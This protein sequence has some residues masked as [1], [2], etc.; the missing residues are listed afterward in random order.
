MYTH[1]EL[2]CQFV[3]DDSL[4]ISLNNL[5][6]TVSS[7]STKK[8]K[9]KSSYFRLCTL[10]IHSSLKAFHSTAVADLCSSH[11]LDLIALT[12]TWIKPNSTPSHLATL[13]QL[14]ILFTASTVRR[15]G[16]DIKLH[17]SFHCHWL[18]FV[19]M[20]HEAGQSAFLHT[21]LYLSTNL[22]HILFS[23]VSWH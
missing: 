16:H 9:C 2:G 8:D 5:P 6:S 23:N 10:N 1:L 22:D 19:L 21:Q 4:D 11:D 3:G 20:C 15:P 12:E 13:L 7:S 14:A 18:R 17:P